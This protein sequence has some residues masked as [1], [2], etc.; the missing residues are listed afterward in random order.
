M[1]FAYSFD[2]LSTA[3]VTFPPILLLLLSFVGQ[4]GGRHHHE[5]VGQ[6]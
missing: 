2:P 5:T 3:D 1:S 6:V 4:S